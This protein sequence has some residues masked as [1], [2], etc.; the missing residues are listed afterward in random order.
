MPNLELE[1]YRNVEL[2]DIV[3]DNSIIAQNLYAALCNM[4][5]KKDNKTCSFSWRSAGDVVATMKSDQTSDYLDFYC[6]SFSV[7]KQEGLV[8]E[9]KVTVEIEKYLNDMG[10]EKESYK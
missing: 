1:L 4:K 8:E 10:W 9:G 6:S 7:E 5:W 3:T 2:C